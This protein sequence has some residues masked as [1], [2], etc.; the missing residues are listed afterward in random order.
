MSTDLKTYDDHNVD[1]TR[2]TGEEGVCVQLTGWTCDGERG[3]L[4]V[5]RQQAGGLAMDLLKFA[6]GQE[7]EE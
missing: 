5:S 1:L 6:H 3:W 7:E 2:H 4:S